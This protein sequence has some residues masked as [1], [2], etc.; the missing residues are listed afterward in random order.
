M[1]PF[2]ITEIHSG[3]LAGYGGAYLGHLSEVNDLVK[4]STGIK[5]ALSASDLA[6]AEDLIRARAVLSD[7]TTLT[8]AGGAKLAITLP[9]VGDRSVRLP[10]A[11]LE[12]NKIDPASCPIHVGVV[13]PVEDQY[14]AFFKM[15]LPFIEQ[16]RLLIRPRRIVMLRTTTNHWQALP[17]EPDA[18]DD[19][20][21]VSGETQ[22]MGEIPVRVET[23]GAIPFDLA[24]PY[25]RGVPF[26]DLV[27]ILEDAGDTVLNLRR[28]IQ[29]ALAE[30]PAADPKA[31]AEFRRDVIDPEVETL[32]RTFKKAI[33]S[34]KYTIGGA[35][36]G[37]IGLSLSAI[38]TG[39]ATAI[40]S[41]LLGAGGV[42]L[43]AKEY[44]A[45]RSKL[46][47]M[48]D[49]PFYLFWRAKRQR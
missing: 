19:V 47:D 26:A 28:G 41:G 48:K 30:H 4:N 16:G 7:L 9:K 32:Q 8:L 6:T 36:V 24:L 18:D 21:I 33:A 17:V 31:T 2:G 20:W 23:D 38:I 37:I 40:A 11:Y 5:T 13:Q 29:K 27:K 25:L 44:S 10:Q 14:V 46:E 35:V 12:K 43:V 15:C 1:K 45:Y 42:G 22:A 3:D 39:G 49:N 34:H